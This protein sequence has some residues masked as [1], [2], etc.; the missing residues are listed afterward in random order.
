MFEE[1]IARYRSISI[2]TNKRYNLVALLI[3]SKKVICYG[4]NDYT[5]NYIDGKA[6]SAV[7]AEYNCC[8]RVPKIKHTLLV[9]R[10]GKC[11]ELRDSRPCSKCKAMLISKGMRH[12]YC[13]NNGGIEKIDLFQLENYMSNSQEKCKKLLDNY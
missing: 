5:R 4:F 2:N 7:H 6:V 1:I 12:I 9:L 10:F 3:K 8:R 13:S 11:G